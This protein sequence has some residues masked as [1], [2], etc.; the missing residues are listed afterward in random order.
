MN[1]YLFLKVEENVSL[2]HIF[3]KNFRTLVG[4][5]RSSRLHQNVPHDPIYLS[6]SVLKV[7]QHLYGLKNS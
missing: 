5:V 2:V 7:V 6:Q 3:V 4:G 1:S